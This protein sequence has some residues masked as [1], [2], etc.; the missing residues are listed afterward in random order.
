M[1]PK[2]EIK[3]MAKVEI[4]KVRTIKPRPNKVLPT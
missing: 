3:K 4:I 2:K 1:I